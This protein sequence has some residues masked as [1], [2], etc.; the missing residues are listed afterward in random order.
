M[1]L[2]SDFFLS[3]F[4]F[5]AQLILGVEDLSVPSQLPNLLAETWQQLVRYDPLN[6]QGV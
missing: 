3:P 1:L 2:Y 6:V 4:M 5:C